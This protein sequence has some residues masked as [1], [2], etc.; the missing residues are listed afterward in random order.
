MWRPIV[1]VMG[2]DVHIRAMW[3]RAPDDQPAACICSACLI[4]C[5][6]TRRDSLIDPDIHW[7]H[8]TISPH[9]QERKHT[10]G[11]KR[12]SIW[13]IYETQMSWVLVERMQFSCKTLNHYLI[14][15]E[16]G[17]NLVKTETSTVPPPPAVWVKHGERPQQISCRANCRPIFFVLK[18]DKSQFIESIRNPDLISIYLRSLLLF[19]WCNDQYIYN[20]FHTLMGFE[21]FMQKAKYK[22]QGLWFPCSVI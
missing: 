10:H 1:S 7:T 5:S 4:C 16:V 18:Q 8:I 2:S 11:T 21:I 6:P 9:T 14:V 13:H 20:I 22:F 12:F 17:N 3:V 15:K 19:P